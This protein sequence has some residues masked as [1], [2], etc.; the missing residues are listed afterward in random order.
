M[1]FAMQESWV[2]VPPLHM[3]AAGYLG[4]LKANKGRSA[5]RKRPTV[6]T[7]AEGSLPPHIPEGDRGDLFEL[8]RSLNGGML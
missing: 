6:A 7:G 3:M 4:I 2:E 1:Y 5:R 8:F